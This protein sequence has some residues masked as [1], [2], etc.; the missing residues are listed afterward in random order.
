[1]ITYKKILKVFQE[2]KKDVTFEEIRWFCAYKYADELTEM[3][4]KDLARQIDGSSI[5]MKTRADIVEC[6]ELW[7]EDS[8]SDKPEIDLESLREELKNWFI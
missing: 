3:G 4:T 8:E 1:M 2:F 6:I 7:F 5:Q